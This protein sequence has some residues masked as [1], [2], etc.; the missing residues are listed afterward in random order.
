MIPFIVLFPIFY[1]LIKS[2]TLLIKYLYSISSNRKVWKSISGK[3]VLVTNVNSE[4]EESLCLI[5]AQKNIKLILIGPNENRLLKLKTKI[6][7]KLEVIHYSIDM[8]HQKDFT[9][10][11]KYDIGLVINRVGSFTDIPEMFVNQNTDGVIDLCIKAPMN[12]L[13]VVMTAMAE[14]HLGY[15]VNIGFHY[16]IKP[17]PRF[18]TVA[19]IKSAYKA[20]SESM[21]YEM[22]PFNVNVE[23]MEMGD[24]LF[25][26]DKLDSSNFLTPDVYK[27]AESII[28]SLGS[29]YFTVPY[30]SH[31]IMYICV[32]ITPRFIIG[33]YRG[34]KMLEYSQNNF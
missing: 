15:V 29:S 31:F 20:W 2:F 13:K 30:F 22:M 1:S 25:S 14:N 18:S 17:S 11:E 19:S 24:I 23:Y 12:L 27:A 34:Y 26:E 21:Y 28:G 3:Y 7:S 6:G 9:F 33:R 5:L 8:T 32:F 4:F 10:L 16:S